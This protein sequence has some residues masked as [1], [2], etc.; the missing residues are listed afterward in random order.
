MDK[1]FIKHFNEVGI[2]DVAEV[3]GKNASLGEMIRHLEPK[4]IAIPNG[5]VVTAAAYRYF[6][7]QTGL[8]EII[9]KTL[10]GLNTKNLADLSKRCRLV[11]EEIKNVEFP[12]E[13][14]TEIIKGYKDLEKT[15]GKNVDVAV[16]SSATAE[17]L[18]G[19]S[20]AGEHDTYLNIR[21]T[22][23]LLSAVRAAMA[24]LFT[25]RATSYRADKGFDHFKIALSVGVQKMVRSDLSCSGVMFTLDTES[26]FKDIVLIN[27]SWGLGEMIVQG[28]V[29]PDEFLVFKPKL[30]DKKLNPI[31]DKR[32]GT[33]NQKMIYS[34]VSQF[35]VSI[36]TTKVVATSQKEKDSWVLSEKEILQLANWG[37]LIEEHYTKYNGKW[38]PMDME[39]AKDGKTG[40]L[41]IVQARPE[42]IHAER[43]FSKV[44]EYILESNVKGKAS[45]I[46]TKGTSVGNKIATG[47]ARVILNP[48]NIRD[49]KKGEVLITG[50]TDPDWEPI[51]K[52]AAAIITDKGGR[53]SHAAIVSRE[54]GIPCIVG[55]ENATNK[56]KTGQMITVDTTGAE[57]IIYENSLSFK[58]IE[59]D[60]KKI[61]KPKT[62]IMMNIATP[63]TAFE[64]S[65]LPN[66]G[67]GLAREEFIIAG[68][69][70]IHPN[71]LINYK[72]LKAK[73]SKIEK[74]IVSEIDKKTAGYPDKIQF[75]IDKL[76][77]GIAKIG[78][79]FYPNPVI[80]RFSDFK[81]NEYR[82]LIGGELYEPQEENPMIGWRGASRYYHPD[83]KDAF[84]LE[85]WAIQKVREEMGIDNIEVMVPFCRTTEEGKKVVEII[86]KFGLRKNDKKLNPLKIMVM[87]EIPSNIILADKFLDVFDGMSIG[88]NDLTQ[89]TVGIDRDGNEKIRSIANEKDQS[90]KDL[91]SSVIKVCKSRGKYIG[92]CGQAPSDYPEFAEFL[93]EQGI[94]SMSLNPDTIVKTTLVVVEKEK[95]LK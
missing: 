28:E 60:I 7:E 48:K 80:V 6:L 53:T 35:H 38:T 22:D 50:M 31:I 8:K 4:G 94:E 83:F 61:G 11:R 24:S 40:E 55:T 10:T 46:I 74:H 19:A 87:C 5:F 72:K 47:K 44:K 29:T 17:D 56:I 30:S 25:E 63:D 69:I 49:F 45:K 75:Y 41:F 39:W 27:G 2:K 76:A 70:G 73:N 85:L 71:A 14:K 81:T 12:Q 36:K 90:V 84:I 37:V 32:L 78:A 43:D 62:K 42:T 92:I 34:S 93:V 79:A 33:K 82:T 3:G 21:G 13:L 15:Y 23:D 9:K 18:P 54:L 77:Y 88:S 67:V 51:M 68:N 91:V 52:I 59:H 57:G 1:K 66:D 16:R 89:L 26:G 64:K 86:D 65:F 58:V 20:F 95:E